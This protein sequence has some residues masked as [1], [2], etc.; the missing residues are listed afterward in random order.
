[1]QILREPGYA[2][3]Q[4]QL[5]IGSIS[6]MI[7][8]LTALY[9]TWVLLHASYNS[10]NLTKHLPT[11]MKTFYIAIASISIFIGVL[12][13]V[14]T[15]VTNNVQYSSVRLLAAFIAFSFAIIFSEWSL[16]RLR[17]A[18]YEVMSKIPKTKPSTSGSNSNIRSQSRG[19]INPMRTSHSDTSLKVQEMSYMKASADANN[20]PENSVSETVER[21]VRGHREAKSAKNSMKSIKV[22]QSPKPLESYTT[23]SRSEENRERHRRNFEAALYKIT[24][25]MVLIGIIGFLIVPTLFAA[26]VTQ[27]GKDES[28]SEGIEDDEA[29]NFEDDVDGWAVIA[30]ILLYLYYAYVPPVQSFRE[31]RDSLLNCEC[32]SVQEA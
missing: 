3:W 32:F 18:L 13:V 20:E 14:G 28:Y 16:Y 29:Y 10:V 9:W 25:L 17:G 4:A 23:K 31:V 8:I 11:K 24:K 12:S 30:A 26:I 21:K 7:T 2:G 1:M 15:L 5:V 22:Q 6:V 27:I 19:N